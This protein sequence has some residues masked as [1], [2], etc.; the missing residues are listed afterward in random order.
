MRGLPSGSESGENPIMPNKQD[1]GSSLPLTFENFRFY[2][3]ADKLYSQ[4]TKKAGLPGREGN[5][6]NKFI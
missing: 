5:D 6:I 2:L 3:L 4:M 1:K